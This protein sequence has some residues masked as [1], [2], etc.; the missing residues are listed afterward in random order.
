MSRAW[1]AARAETD[2]PAAWECWANET[3]RPQRLPKPDVLVVADL[4]ANSS[5][6]S[7]QD[8]ETMRFIYATMRFIVALESLQK[9]R[10]DIL[11]VLQDM[12]HGCSIQWG[13]NNVGNSLSAC[14]DITSAATVICCPPVSI[15]T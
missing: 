1:N 7:G 2:P 9:L 5:N 11:S 13:V 10:A 8:K 3:S 6:L 4:W 12:N 15:A 14:C